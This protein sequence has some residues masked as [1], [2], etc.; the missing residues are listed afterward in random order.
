MSGHLFLLRGDLTRL[1]C[2]AWLLPTDR[3]LDLTCAWRDRL[4]A[5]LPTPPSD[6]ALD[7]CRSF[8]SQ[9]LQH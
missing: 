3:R 7:G 1:H 8:A 5:E 4:P 9:R 2:D 6:W